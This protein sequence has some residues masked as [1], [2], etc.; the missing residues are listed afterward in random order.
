[1]CDWGETKLMQEMIPSLYVF[2]KDED[3][4]NVK[5]LH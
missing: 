2:A 3:A 5:K 4:I 1:M